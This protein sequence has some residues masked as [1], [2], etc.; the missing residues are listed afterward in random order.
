MERFKN[1]L[2]DAEK[3]PSVITVMANGGQSLGSAQILLI[4][5]YHREKKKSNSFKCVF[6]RVL[7]LHPP[8]PIPNSPSSFLSHKNKDYSFTISSY[9]LDQ[10]F[11]P[12]ISPTLSSR[13]KSPSNLSS[14]CCQPGQ[15]KN[16]VAF[17][18]KQVVKDE[19]NGCG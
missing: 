8:P 10:R 12:C 16:A 7:L 5:M 4:V 13:T 1:M 14:L 6:G 19:F 2:P 11:P 9:F 3:L 17:T 15:W 18:D